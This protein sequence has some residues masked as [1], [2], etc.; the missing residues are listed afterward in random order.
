MPITDKFFAINIRKYLALG[1]DHE[2]GEPALIKL[3]S[4]FSCPKNPD[5]ERFLKKSAIEFTKKNQSVTY[6]VFSKDNGEMLGYFTLALKPLTI[7]GETVS[8]TTRKKLL[9][10]S[11]L[12]EK[13]DTY[14]MSA[15]LIAQ[16]GKNYA[17]D[18]DKDITGKELIELAWIIIEKAQY[19][20]GGMVTFLEA[21]NEE[22]L[23]SFY[24]NNRFSRFDTRQATSGADETHELVQL[25][26]LL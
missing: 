7:R 19:M 25:L 20:F 24:Q 18:R 8:N 17:D 15:Y 26:R 4:G 1:D 23:L 12:D 3:L 2:A 11:E 22:K 13:S 14:T 5:V 6:L 10:V 21:E 16:L 9:R